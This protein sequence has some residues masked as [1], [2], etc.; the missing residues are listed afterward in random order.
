MLMSDLSPFF[1]KIL[2]FFSISQKDPIDLKEKKD[3]VEPAKVTE[4]IVTETE[5][6][7]IIAPKF[8]PR[9]PILEDVQEDRAST[10]A[11]PRPSVVDIEKPPLS[12]PSPIP[13]NP[14][15]SE[16]KSPRSP[17][18]TSDA[19]SASKTD[20]TNLPETSSSQSQKIDKPKATEAPSQS[21]KEDEPKETEAA[22]QAAIK[23]FT[24]DK[25]KSKVTGKT[26][27]GWL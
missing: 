5:Q 8:R 22:P 14:T 10:S 23:T 1:A 21:K 18:P 13:T 24:T 11:S 9:T 19:K 2:N 7:P 3:S 15:S 6:I 4:A 20:E 25:G 27:T 16:M 17:T 12:S 26:I